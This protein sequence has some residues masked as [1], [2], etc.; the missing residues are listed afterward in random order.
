MLTAKAILVMIVINFQSQQVE[1]F[2]YEQASLDQCK[3]SIA[4]IIKVDVP[5]NYL[6][7]FDC[8]SIDELGEG[9]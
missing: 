8:V 9:V 4:E 5:P 3:A 7:V 1:T 6:A 2:H